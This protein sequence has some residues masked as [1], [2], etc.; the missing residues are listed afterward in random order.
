MLLE[1]IGNLV[2]LLMHVGSAE[3]CAMNCTCCCCRLLFF[4]G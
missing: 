1:L 3:D 2:F 4:E